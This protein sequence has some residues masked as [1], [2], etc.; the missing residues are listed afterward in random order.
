M[1]KGAQKLKRG[2]IISFSLVNLIN[3]PPPREIPEDLL[4][5][6]IDEQEWGRKFAVPIAGAEDSRYGPGQ[7]AIAE[8]VEEWLRR[9]ARAA[10]FRKILHNYPDCLL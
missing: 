10:A 7:A 3:P 1:T 6:W 2:D 4:P 9:E 5:R 8:A